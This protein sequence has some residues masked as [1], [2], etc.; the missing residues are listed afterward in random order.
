MDGVKILH[1]SDLHLDSPVAGLNAQQRAVRRQEL[2][3]SF[4]NALA[5]ARQRQVQVV[6]LPGDLFDGADVS[7]DTVKFVQNLFAAYSDMRFF[8]ALGNHDPLSANIYAAFEGM[9]HVTVF[10]AEWGSVELPEWNARVYG[11]GFAHSKQAEP[12][13]RGFRAEKDERV[14]LMVL[15]GELVQGMTGES[16]YN[17]VYAADIA[18]CGADYLALGHTHAYSGI[19]KAGG[20]HYAYCGTHEGHGFDEC[21]PKGVIVGT[22]GKGCV[23]L[24]FAATCL[25]QY[26]RL[27]IDVT[28]C[29]TVEDVLAAV[30]TCTNPQDLF[31]IALSGQFDGELQLPVLQNGVQAYFAKFVN[32]TRPGYDLQALAQDYTLKGLF[33]RGILE[34]LERAQ[35]EEEKTALL[36]AADLA[37]RLF[38]KGGVQ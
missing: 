35:S 20:T 21:G 13:L 6:L 36:D 5:L 24:E 10:G 32:E 4:A 17:P 27:E 31:R 9:P 25:R 38:D 26:R 23:D 37:V 34:R 14:I 30:N 29:D 7:G 33:A 15:H 1:I 11:V 3:Q 2:R 28:G 19:L 18:A 8:L 12:L 16:A 22:V